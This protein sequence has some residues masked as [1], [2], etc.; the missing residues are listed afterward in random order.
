[1]CVCV[2]VYTLYIYIYIYSIIEYILVTYCFSRLLIIK[3]ETAL[4]SSSQNILATELA[5]YNYIRKHYS[6]STDFII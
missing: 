1:M 3:V 2:C 6:S 5:S 4:H